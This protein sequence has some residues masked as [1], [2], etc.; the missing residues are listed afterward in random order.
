M[1]Q[2]HVV[3][4]GDAVAPTDVLNKGG[5]WEGRGLLNTWEDEESVAILT[6]VTCAILRVQ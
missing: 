1:E 5:V 4:Q 3:A 6:L 2:M